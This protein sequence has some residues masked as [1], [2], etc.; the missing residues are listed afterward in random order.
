MAQWTQTTEPYVKVHEIVKSAPLNPTVGEDLI[1]GVVLIS[2]AGPSVPTLISGQKDFIKNFAS[3]D[4]SIDYL[5]SLKNLYEGTDRELPAQ[6]WMNAYRLAGSNTMLVCRAS[7]ADNIYFSKAISVEDKNDYILRDGLLMKRMPNRFKFVLDIDSDNVDHDQDGWGIAVNGAGVLGNRTTDRGAQYDYY[8]DNLPD[9]IDQLNETSKF[10]SP[11]FEYYTDA[12][13]EN[14][15]TIDSDSTVEQK[16][17]VR[18]VIFEEVYLGSDFL[19]TSDSRYP[20]KGYQYI[21]PCTPDW[22]SVE[23]DKS[24]VIDLNSS[25]WSGFDEIPYY[26]TNQYNSAT[27]LS[28]R[29]RRFNHDAVV[30]KQLSDND[31]TQLTKTG[32]SPYTVLTSVLDTFISGG[33]KEPS[34]EILD[35]D[36]FEIAVFDPSVNDEVSFFNVG[37]ILGRGDMEVSEI[38][39]LISMIQFELPEDL[40]DLGLDYYDYTYTAEGH[41]NKPQVFQNLTIDPTES[42]MLSVSDSDLKKALDQIILDEVY[43]TEGL[44]DLGNT[45]LSYQ[46]YMANY[47]VN[48]NYFYPISTVNSTNYMTIGTNI[49][50]IS[51]NSYKLYASAPWDIDTGTFGWKYYASPAVLYWEAVSRNRRNKEEFRSI[52]GQDGGIVQYQRPVTEFNKKTRQLLLSKKVNTVK[53]NI[54][55]QAWNMNDNFTKQSENNIM[56]DE[57]NSRLAIRI[58]KA[59]PRLLW[60]Y[61]GRQISEVTCNDMKSTIDYFFKTVILPMSYTVEAYQVFCKYDEVLARQNKVNVVINVRFFRA[62]KYVNVYDVLYDTG[63]DISEPGYDA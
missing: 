11:S 6:M 18:S 52:L 59:M 26:A 4:I 12:K 29:I 35:R 33:T 27:N 14:S 43:T 47:A 41:I 55:T 5:N 13:G 30:T 45:E 37:S 3:K 9:L 57:A 46:N 7:K 44:C 32:N 40:H 54:Q 63:A 58:A 8:V 39:D 15:I 36:F 20:E 24:K 23:R 25:D 42:K 49:S 2:D 51:Q 38:N 34:D 19:D 31:K 17:S 10:F 50:K 22:E 28:I 62:L 61:I 53:W 16:A 1:I 48:D 60:Q 21:I 56:S